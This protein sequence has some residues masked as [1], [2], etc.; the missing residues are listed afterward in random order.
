M[1]WVRLGVDLALLGLAIAAR[2]RAGRLPS[3]AGATAAGLPTLSLV[4]LFV[5]AGLSSPHAH[6]ASP[7]GIALADGGCAAAAAL[8]WTGAR[9][10]LQLRSI[11]RVPLLLYGAGIG[12]FFFGEAIAVTVLNS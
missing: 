3:A 6:R 9:V 7:S 4:V 8:S 11:W 5:I 10:S 2:V 1:Q 12:L